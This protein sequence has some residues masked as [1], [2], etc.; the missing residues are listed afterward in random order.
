VF[1]SAAV[2]CCWGALE[3]AMFEF[4]LAAAR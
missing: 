2:N 3:G 1:S 4:V